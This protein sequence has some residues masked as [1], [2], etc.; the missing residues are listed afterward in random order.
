MV[1]EDKEEIL[2]DSAGRMPCHGNDSDDGAGSR[3]S[4][5]FRYLGWQCCYCICRWN[6]CRGRSISDFQWGRTGISCKY[7]K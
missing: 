4:E 6:R 7:G 3:W 1:N 2:N 5:G